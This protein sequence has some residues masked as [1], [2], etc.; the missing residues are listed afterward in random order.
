MPPAH[1]YQAQD[2]WQVAVKEGPSHQMTMPLPPTDSLL[3]LPDGQLQGLG[4]AHPSGGERAELQAEWAGPA[5]REATSAP[6]RHPQH[7]PCSCLQCDGTDLTPKIQDLKP[8]CI[9]FLNI[10]R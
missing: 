9:V 2:P 7:P 1:V 8:Q 10:P 3:R 6:H 4:Q 5:G